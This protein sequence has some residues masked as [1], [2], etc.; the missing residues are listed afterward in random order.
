M[1]E[2]A[3]GDQDRSGG[4]DGHWLAVYSKGRA[5]PKFF[6]AAVEVFHRRTFSHAQNSRFANTS[7]QLIANVQ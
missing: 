7:S 5:C 1:H 6:D 2:Y 4:T 3:R